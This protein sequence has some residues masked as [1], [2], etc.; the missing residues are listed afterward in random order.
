LN[1][2]PAA[3]ARKVKN[4]KCCM[5]LNVG[6]YVTDNMEDNPNSNLNLLIQPAES[7]EKISRG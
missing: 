6:C 7:S 4:K 2:T 3:G 1:F 5:V